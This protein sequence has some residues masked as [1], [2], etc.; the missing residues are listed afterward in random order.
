[1]TRFATGL[2][3]LFALGLTTPAAQAQ[4]S[5]RSTSAQDEKVPPRTA[6]APMPRRHTASGGSATPGA[7]TPAP[8]S[9]PTRTIPGGPVITF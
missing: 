7:A 4:D 2:A 5:G 9:S 1:M 8:P 6:T 3:A